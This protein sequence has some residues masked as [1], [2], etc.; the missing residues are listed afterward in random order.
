MNV[1]TALVPLL[2]RALTLTYPLMSSLVTTKY[3][4]PLLFSI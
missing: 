3:Y 4:F 2:E 1:A